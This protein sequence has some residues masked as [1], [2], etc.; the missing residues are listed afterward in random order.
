MSLTRGAGAVVLITPGLVAHHLHPRCHPPSPLARTELIA[1][2]DPQKEA[3]V[4]YRRDTRGC[5]IQAVCA[6]QDQI[7][8]AWI[9]A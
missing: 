6:K 3:F 8:T 5:L 1:M 7:E 9:A 2:N 4:A